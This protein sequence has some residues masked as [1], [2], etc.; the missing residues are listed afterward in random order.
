MRGRPTRA[1]YRYDGWHVPVDPSWFDGEFG[2]PE[3]HSFP[4]HY[5]AFAIPEYG[6]F[7]QPYY[8]ICDYLQVRAWVLEFKAPQGPDYRDQSTWRADFQ[9][10][11]ADDGTGLAY[12][13]WGDEAIRDQTMSSRIVRLNNIRD[14]VQP[15]VRQPKFDYKPELEAHLRL[16]E[17]VALHPEAVGLSTEYRAQLERD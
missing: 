6:G 14:I 10:Y 9:P 1:I 7:S 15:R 4:F 3:I 2:L 8:F 13:R 16:K 12:F 11:R 17:Y 5:Y